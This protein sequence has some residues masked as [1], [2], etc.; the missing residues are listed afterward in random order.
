MI[1]SIFINNRIRKS[2]RTNEHDSYEKSERIGI[3]Y[4]ADEFEE[5]TIDQVQEALEQDRKFVSRLGFSTTI[6]KEHSEEEAVFTRKDISATGVV[7][8]EIVSKFIEKPFYFL[9][10]LDTSEDINYKYVLA[11]S[12]ALCKVGFQTE[13]YHALL[14]MYM[15]LSK[16]KSES[17]KDLISYLKK[18]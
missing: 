13:G 7:K 18:I 12:K 14:M 3:L 11:S 8:K 2:Q 6:P 15:K 1:K 17:V 9:I 10:S 16:N 5:A 4:N